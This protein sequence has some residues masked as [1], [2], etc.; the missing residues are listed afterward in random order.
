VE[1][2]DREERDQARG[3]RSEVD[4]RTEARTAAPRRSGD[5]EADVVQIIIITFTWSGP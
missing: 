1:S 2:G 5:S 3:G 4:K